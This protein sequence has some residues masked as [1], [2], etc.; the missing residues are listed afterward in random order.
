MSEIAL[1]RIF[2]GASNDEKICKFCIE[3]VDYQSAYIA[4]NCCCEISHMKCI[5]SSIY[6]KEN[7]C[8]GNNCIKKNEEESISKQLYKMKYSFFLKKEKNYSKMTTMDIISYNCIYDKDSS[9]KRE[10][11]EIFVSIIFDIKNRINITKLNRMKN[12]YCDNLK[13]N[14]DNIEFSRN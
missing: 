14:R 8:T 4:I 6:R 5:L 11:N 1:Q 2:N 13:I 10:F 7:T 12:S 9:F 3:P